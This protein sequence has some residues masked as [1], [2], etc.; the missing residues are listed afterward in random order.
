MF[1]ADDGRNF[2]S[3]PPN[4]QAMAV[5]LA[6]YHQRLE[7]LNHITAEEM[8]AEIK[9]SGFNCVRCGH[10]CI[11]LKVDANDREL[12]QAEQQWGKM[13]LN[14]KNGSGQRVFHTN[15]LHL[16]AFEVERIVKA[17]GMKWFDVARPSPPRGINRNSELLSML[18]L[19]R[20][21]STSEH[22]GDCYFY[23]QK[24][25]ACRIYDDR[26]LVCRSH[27]F[28]LDVE[29]G[30]P[31]VVLQCPY[32]TFG[33]MSQEESYKYAKATLDWYRIY[34]KL[35]YKFVV[36][37]MDLDPKKTQEDGGIILKANMKNNK[38]M[39]RLMDSRGFHHVLMRRGKNGKPIYSLF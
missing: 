35:K 3:I 10:C 30:E 21:N 4:I 17:T 5:D 38:I 12:W 8:A 28:F 19:L 26:P 39:Y 32:G 36:S 22:L 9:K 33:E 13:A 37:T 27:P 6:Q 20:Y 23:D 31:S 18:W 25:E 2:Y 24:A 15:R 7:W 34:L 16:D 1:E 14:A 11:S 29:G